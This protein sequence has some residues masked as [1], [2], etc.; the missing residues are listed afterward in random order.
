MLDGGMASAGE[1][2][3]SAV[4]VSGSYHVADAAGL[5]WSLHPAYSISSPAQF[6]MP[7]SGVSL[8]VQVLA[9]GK[10]QAATVLH[11][12]AAV[13]HSTQTVARDGFA[14][15]MFLPGAAQARCSGRG[16]ARR[17]S[18]RRAKLHSRCAGLDRVSGHGARPAARERA[19]TLT[20]GKSVPGFRTSGRGLR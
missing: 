19:R 18:R 20:A 6:Y 1:R 14:S 4:P 11:R 16:S 3:A 13:R 9:D 8:T 7:D 10:V 5:I 12:Q 15:T 17:L 2:R